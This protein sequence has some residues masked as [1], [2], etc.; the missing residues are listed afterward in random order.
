MSDIP[1]SPLTSL[2]RRNN[3]LN[4]ANRRLDD[5]GGPA[6]IIADRDV[7]ADERRVT[8]VALAPINRDRELRLT[9]FTTGRSW[10]QTIS[11]LFGAAAEPSNVPDEVY[12]TPDGQSFSIQAGNSFEFPFERVLGGVRDTANEIGAFSAAITGG[13]LGGSR[14]NPWIANL[15]AFSMASPITIII[16]LSFEIGKYGLWDAYREV[17]LPMA[18]LTA[19]AIPLTLNSLTVRGA[20]PNSGQ[21]YRAAVIGLSDVLSN[22]RET[23]D[24]TGGAVNTLVARINEF[25][26][27]ATRA[28]INSD[29][30]GLFSVELGAPE[31]PV[32]KIPA[33]VIQDVTAN[34]STELDQ[35]GYPIGASVNLSMTSLKPP[36]MAETDGYIGGRG[37]Y[38]PRIGGF[39]LAP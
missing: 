25:A 2:E 13:A 9:R 6:T 29:A 19:L 23:A 34:Y 12:L 36:A 39:G 20:L 17:V 3:E 18:N 5:A 22:V 30:L 37:Q 1:R 38:F 11:S 4:Q 27:A 33:V 10:R 35:F 21:A 28:V 24:N 32:L 16:T 7:A 26:T 14:F 8:N 31:R 15:P